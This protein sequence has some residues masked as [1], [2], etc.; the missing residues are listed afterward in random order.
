MSTGSCRSRILLGFGWFFLLLPFVFFLTFDTTTTTTISNQPTTQT[1]Y[2][3]DSTALK[4]E[5]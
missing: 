2:N 4:E 1:L 3:P 5:A